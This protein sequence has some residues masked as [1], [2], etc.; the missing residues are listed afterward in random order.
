MPAAVVPAIIIGGAT[1]LSA[2]ASLIAGGQQAKAAEKANEENLAYARE[3]QARLEQAKQEEQARQAAEE[4]RLKPWREAQTSAMEKYRQM[5]ENPEISE[6]TKL[7]LDEEEK[8][9][10]KE[11]A[12]KG[13]LFSG[14]AAELRQKARERIIAEETE[15]AKSML[16][17]VMSAAPPG[18]GLMPG[19]SQYDAL[20]ASLNPKSTAVTNTGLSGVTNSLL[21]GAN[22]YLQYQGAK[23]GANTL[24]GLFGQY[25]YATTGATANQAA[26]GGAGLFPTI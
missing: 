22:S 3:E 19:T 4:E 6:L 24:K 7:R 10:N 18:T 17:T 20:I 11:L 5:A 16:Q 2:G 8:A 21:G 15:N 1:V 23:E 12:A 26:S 9:I 13:L 14:P 25:P